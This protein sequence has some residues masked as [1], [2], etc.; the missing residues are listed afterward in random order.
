[1]SQAVTGCMLL[2]TQK[3]TKYEAIPCLKDRPSEGTDLSHP[4]PGGEVIPSADGVHPVE[5]QSLGAVAKAL[6]G[7]KATRRLQWVVGSKEYP[8]LST[9]ACPQHGLPLFPFPCLKK[10]FLICT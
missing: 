4:Q 2:S 3:V 10:D 8:E 5:D 7:T 1:M 9:P 6:S